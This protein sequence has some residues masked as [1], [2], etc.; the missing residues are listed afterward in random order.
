MITGG[1]LPSNVSLSFGLKAD[2]PENPKKSNMYLATDT[3]EYFV[4]YKEGVW[5]LATPPITEMLTIDGVVGTD[6]ELLNDPNSYQITKG[7]TRTFAT[8]KQ[9]TVVDISNLSEIVS[10]NT[11]FDYYCNDAEHKAAIYVNGVSCGAS[12]SYTSTAWRTMNFNV[13]VPLK[14][15]DTIEFRVWGANS[16]DYY[17]RAVRNLKLN[18]SYSI[19]GSGGITLV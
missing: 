18:I 1:S 13:T 7:G 12:G 15:G 17:Q 6:T 4:C 5:V 10:F 3:E 2:R 11:A 8:V 19:S 9:F 14:V 16:S